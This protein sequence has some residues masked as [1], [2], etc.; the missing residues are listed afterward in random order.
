MSQ[1]HVRSLQKSY[2]VPVRETGLKALRGVVRRQHSTVEAIRDISFDIEPGEIVGFIGPN[3]AGKTTTLKILSGLLHPTAGEVL[4]AG[5]IPWERRPDYLR[6]ISMV[7]GNKS[8]VM[9]DIPSL[10]SYVVLGE[11]YRVPPRE[12]QRRIDELAAMLGVTDL[13][14]KP[15][16]MLSLGE[17]MKCELVASL[18]HQP[19]VLFLDEPTLGLDVSVQRRLREFIREYNRRTGATIILTS[20]YM[21]D[22]EALCSRLLVIHEGKLIYD[23][24]LAGLIEKLAPFKL[25]RLTLDGDHADGALDLPLGTVKSRIHHG[26][27]DVRVRLNE[28]RRFGG[29]W[30][31][32]PRIIE[33]EAVEA[34][35]S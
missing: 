33:A 28:D 10:D 1:V 20:H 32:A 30:G 12:L 25:I 34:G 29:A 3:G 35:G 11:I 4:V 13:I 14:A 6:Q 22:V 23:G 26:L 15:V 18:L 19:A 5:E 24:A 27:R 9:W 2:R 21:A 16:R 8:Q 31:E 17:R 7:M